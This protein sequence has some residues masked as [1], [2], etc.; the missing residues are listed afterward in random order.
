[1]GPERLVI[2]EAWV[3]GWSSRAGCWA[4]DGE[5]GSKVVVEEKMGRPALREAGSQAQA[6]KCLRAGALAEGLAHG[7][8]APGD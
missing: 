3:A 1:M 7:L 2:V 6:H 8:G 4:E 5:G